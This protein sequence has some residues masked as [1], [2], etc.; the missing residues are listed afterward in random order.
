MRLKF[1]NNLLLEIKRSFLQALEAFY[2]EKEAESIFYL[3]SDF[4]LG[5][6]R[7]DM[8]NEKEGRLSESEILYFEKAFIKLEQ[9]MPIQ[10]VI[11]ETDF[12]N[13]N[14]L[15]NEHVLIPRPETEELV[16]M[17]LEENK[18]KTGLRI[19]DIG[20][21]SGCIGLSIKK[22]LSGAELWLMD[23][24]KEALDLAK[25]NAERNQIEARFVL[26][27]ILS[28]QEEY[29][30]FDIIISNPPY[31][32]EARKNKLAKQV[33]D[34][35]PSMALFVPDDDVLIFYRAIREFASKY[36]KP[37]AKIYLELNEELAI[38]TKSIFPK[39]LWDARILKDLSSKSRFLIV[40]K[41]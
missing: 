36:V 19:L 31:V 24:S 41:L 1:G 28:P 25:L 8:L 39:P 29:P 40:S 26:D 21:G 10:Y 32:E 20:C 11:G 37:D 30:V 17:L 3:L 4:H 2:D 35:E 14:F 13:C 18:N 38:E 27:D 5:I 7:L 9:G 16:S 15:V 12:L 23:L 34:F 33:I 22:N 6:D